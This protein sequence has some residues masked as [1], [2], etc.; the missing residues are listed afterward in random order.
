MNEKAVSAKFVEQFGER[1]DLYPEVW[2]RHPA[3]G[4]SFRIDFIGFDRKKELIGPI[5]FE[6]KDPERWSGVEGHF[7]NFTAAVKQCC[8]YSEMVI[9]SQFNEK[10][11]DEFVGKR[12]RY[13]FLYH[14]SAAW[15]YGF[16]LDDHP[17]SH[18]AI[19][20]LSI[21]GKYGV[22]AV[23]FD[24]NAD[25]WLLTLAGNS[26]FSVKKGV[27]TLLLKHNVSNRKGSAV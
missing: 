5:G 18:R 16:R 22:G 9:N 3:Y 17:S 11:H 6:I 27:S 15:A 25:D 1:F 4:S 13:V 20:V 23:C 8:D 26:A 19:G 7:T 24:P 21:A 10:E 14:V 2:L 12:L